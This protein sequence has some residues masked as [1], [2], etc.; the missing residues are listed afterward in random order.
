MPNKRTSAIAKQLPVPVGLIERRSY[1]IR[2]QKVMLDSHVPTTE[3]RPK[4][5]LRAVSSFLRVV[6]ASA[7]AVAAAV[8][9]AASLIA[10]LNYLDTFQSILDG[11]MPAIVAT[12][13]KAFEAFSNPTEVSPG[14]ADLTAQ[15]RLFRIENG[16]KCQVIRLDESSTCQGGQHPVEVILRDGPR[17]GSKVWICSYNVTKPSTS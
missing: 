4:V 6:R 13:R 11:P 8:L 16:T 1:L 14:F 2:G 12:D 10:Y 3:Q 7:I 5:V 15:G 17:R 9:G